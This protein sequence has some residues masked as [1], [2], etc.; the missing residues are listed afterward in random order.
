MAALLQYLRGHQHF[1][2]Q[3]RQ[4]TSGLMRS[5]GKI[6]TTGHSQQLQWKE[7][8]LR[9]TSQEWQVNYSLLPAS[10]LSHTKAFIHKQYDFLGY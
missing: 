4:E 9:L 1:P 8:L 3:G 6:H 7:T 5:E 10:V 2:V